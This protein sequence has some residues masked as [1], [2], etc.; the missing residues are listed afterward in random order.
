VRVAADEDGGAVVVA[1]STDSVSDNFN[2]PT[3]AVTVTVE[4]VVGSF[5]D[6]WPALSVPLL[7][8]VAL[9]LG[10]AVAALRERDVVAGAPLAVLMLLVATWCVSYGG[11]LL[12]GDPALRLR[13]AHVTLAVVAYVPVAWFVFA[14]EYTGR[15]PRVTPRLAAALLVVPTTTAVLAV[16]GHP[17]LLSGGEGGVATAVR[18][19]WFWVHVAHSYLL[20]AAGTGL[21][22]L[23]CAVSADRSRHAAAVLAAAGVPWVANAAFLAGAVP[24]D[25]DPTPF[26][27]VVTGV[28]FTVS[29][30]DWE[31]FDTLPVAREVARDAVIETM[32]DGVVVLSEEDRVVDTNRAAEEFLAAF[33]GFEACLD[34]LPAE[35]ELDRAGDRRRYEL[36]ESSF[37]HLGGLVSGR[38]VTI[39]DV[40]RT[41]RHQQRL[42]VLNRVLRH[43]LRNDLNVVQGHAE[44]IAADPSVAE[45]SAAIIGSKATRLVGLATKVREAERTLGRADRLVTD[46]DVVELV[47][48]RVTEARREQPFAEFVLRVPDDPAT[49][50]SSDLLGLAVDNLLE[51]AVVHTTSLSP[52]VEVTVRRDEETGTVEVSV[53]DDGPG[54]PRQER[55][56]LVDGQETPLDHG[57]GIG[58]WLVNWIV[59]ESM[60][61]VSF[62]ENDPTGSVVTLRLPLAGSTE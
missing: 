59:S 16:V 11:E 6:G 10:V 1:L 61:T 30:V 32:D 53:A 22:V 26:A 56:V 17:V 44:F 21:F 40:T 58:L 37:E 18:G 2:R 29:L 24:R 3:L 8:A 38:L 20:L 12:A 36:R 42:A 55:E 60:G 39:R 34:D 35:V 50:R 49:V 14:V 47:T 4:S 5:V 54:I 43:D 41:H 45:E 7:V 51:N 13:F 46:V 52:T 62:G 19:P 9:A 25:V 31:V 15:G 33:E 48:E 27:F 23:L 57:S 28:V